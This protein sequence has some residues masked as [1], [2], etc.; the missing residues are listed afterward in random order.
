[1]ATNFTSL[2]NSRKDIINKLAAEVLATLEHARI[3]DLV[4][5]DDEG[6]PV[7]LVDTQDLTR[8][9]VM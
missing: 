1:M 7:G 2:R 4:V 5:V 6:K 9:R 3:D 8:L